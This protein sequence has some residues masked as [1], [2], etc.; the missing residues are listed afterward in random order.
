M[1]TY[2]KVVSKF[3][4]RLVSY[5]ICR[6]PDYNERMI[7]NGTLLEY[8]P[9]EPTLPVIPK[10]KLF[11]FSDLNAARRCASSGRNAEVWTCKAV[12]PRHVFRYK[13]TACDSEIEQFWHKRAKG[14][15]I[16]ADREGHPHTVFADSVTLIEKVS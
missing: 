14:T 11:L 8:V 3:Q 10:S 5:N 9:G 12:K 2:F 16:Y 15:N 6:S 1:R 4:D 13:T 7:Q